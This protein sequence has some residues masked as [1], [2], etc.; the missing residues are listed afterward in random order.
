MKFLKG[1]YHL[2]QPSC[3]G[4]QKNGVTNTLK[5]GHPVVLT[6]GSHFYF[7]HY[8]SLST[9]EPKAFGGFAPLKKVY[10][11]E[12]IP[13]DASLEEAERIMGVQGN[14]WTEYM[15]NAKHVEYMIFPRIAALAEVAWQDEKTKDWQRFRTK[16]NRMYS[17]YITSDIN[18][19]PSAYRPQISY[20]LTPDKD[21]LKV[22]IETELEAAIYYTINGSHA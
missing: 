5:K 11:Y 2:Q 12:P 17:R 19:A 18:A 15:P 7:D 1:N 10:D 22:T 6:T 21:K 13:E 16:M 4:V 3:T 9:H 20:E 8:Q 14:V